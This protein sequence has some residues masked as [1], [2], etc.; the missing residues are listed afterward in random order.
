MLR[1]STH[2]IRLIGYLCPW[3][4]EPCRVSDVVNSLPQTHQMIFA[5]VVR[6]HGVK[7]PLG[8]VEEDGVGADSGGAGI[9]SGDPVGA[10]DGGGPSGRGDGWLQTRK[11][12]RR[13]RAREYTVKEVLME[14][15]KMT[16]G[17]DRLLQVGRWDG[18]R[19]DA[20]DLSP[21]FTLSMHNG[22]A[23][24]L[25]TIIVTSCYRLA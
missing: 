22:G 11:R 13:Q 9:G 16:G 23:G 18:R 25:R 24:A 2:R 5:A 21:H 12:K 20:C 3:A 17:P 4:Q 7:A 6:L 1:S 8:S 14:C 10:G 15:E 19:E